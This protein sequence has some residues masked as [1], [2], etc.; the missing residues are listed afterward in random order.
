MNV[1]TNYNR[2]KNKINYKY[3]LLLKEILEHRDFSDILYEINGFADNKKWGVTE[4]N[5]IV[6]LDENDYRKKIEFVNYTTNSNA[7]LKIENIT[8]NSITNYNIEKRFEN[9][10]TKHNDQHKKNKKYINK[11][12]NKKTKPKPKTKTKTKTLTNFH[13]YFINN[14]FYDSSHLKSYLCS[15]GNKCICNCKSNNCAGDC[16][17]AFYYCS[18]NCHLYYDKFCWCIYLDKNT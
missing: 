6:C 10:N 3:E 17:C 15:C 11:S 7:D 5:N 4:Q 12:K 18:N 16:D 2:N 13:Q 9:I 14:N 8:N 1:N